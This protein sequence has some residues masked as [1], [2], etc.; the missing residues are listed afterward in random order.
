MDSVSHERTETEELSARFLRVL[1]ASFKQLS[2]HKLFPPT[3][4]IFKLLN[5]N[6]MRALHLLYRTPGMAQKEL[7]EIL[8]IT[9]AAI[10]TAVKSLEKLELV[11]RRED[12]EDARQKR[13]YLSDFGRTVIRQNQ[14]VRDKAVVHLL[15]ALPL[16]E[17]RMIVEA[18]EKAMMTWRDDQA[19][20]PP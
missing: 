17:Q 1:E 7:A 10:S 20:G 9:P 14:A 16:E 19:T 3:N 6:Q 13:L 5:M 11:E 8:E 2:N 4:S 15:G 18:L 12:S